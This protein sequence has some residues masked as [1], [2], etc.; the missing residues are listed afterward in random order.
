M[1]T[2]EQLKHILNYDPESGI[3]TWKKPTN[4]RFKVG[5]EA[6]TKHGRGYLEITVNRNRFLAHRLAWFYVYGY[7]PK[8]LDHINGV[9]DDNRISNLRLATGSQNNANRTIS[10][11]NNTSGYKGVCWSSYHKKW[12][13]HCRRKHIGFYSTAEEAAKA[14]DAKAKELFG[15]YAKLNLP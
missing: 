14:Y 9:R 7:M 1:I 5:S 4:R 6:G 2:H 12:K 8:M 15:E 10:K 3:F 11:S 13:A